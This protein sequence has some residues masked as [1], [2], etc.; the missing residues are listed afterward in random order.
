MRRIPRAEKSTANATGYES[1]SAG[2]VYPKESIPYRRVRVIR[3]GKLVCGPTHVVIFARGFFVAWPVY[4]VPRRREQEQGVELILT[5]ISSFHDMST[6][7]WFFPSQMTFLY[8]RPLPTRLALSNH[9][10]PR[11]APQLTLSDPNPNDVYRSVCSSLPNSDYHTMCVGPVAASL[12]PSIP[13][14]T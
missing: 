11:S 13:F 6:C 14:R 1:V 9:L 10:L 3:R 8:P 7:Q 5:L 12:S 2:R 4:R